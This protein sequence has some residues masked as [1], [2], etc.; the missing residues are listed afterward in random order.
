MDSTTLLS[1][2]AACVAALF[3]LLTVIIGWIGA[4]IVSKQDETMTILQNLETRIQT[5]INEIEVR[6]VRLETIIY[7]GQHKS[8]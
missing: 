6:L 7:E 5:R 2:A 1:G 8:V 3:G 4:R